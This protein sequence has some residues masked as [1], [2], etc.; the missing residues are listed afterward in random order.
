MAKAPLSVCVQLVRRCSNNIFICYSTS[1]GTDQPVRTTTHTIAAPRHVLGLGKAHAI[2]TSLA[3]M[4]MQCSCWHSS[5]PFALS[6]T[7]PSC[8]S[9]LLLQLHPSGAPSPRAAAAY[10]VQSCGHLM[11]LA[12]WCSRRVAVMR[13]A[14]ETGVH[15]LPQWHVL[16]QETSY[17][18]APRTHFG[19]QHRPRGDDVHARLSQCHGCADR[20]GCG[21]VCA[22]PSRYACAGDPHHQG[23]HCWLRHSQQATGAVCSR[24]AKQLVCV[25]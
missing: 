14:V 10:S 22:P 8:V 24:V 7:G 9:L 25:A 1:I 13:L 12:S 4:A 5:E 3:V 20:D 6:S 21:G 16:D 23:H 15:A 17:A 19:E 18:R 2:R 11:R